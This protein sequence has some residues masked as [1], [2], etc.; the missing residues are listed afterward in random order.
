ME[1][2]TIIKLHI[3]L[4][5]IIILKCVMCS[6]STG[7]VPQKQGNFAQKLDEYFSTIK[8]MANIIEDLIPGQ[9]FCLNY[10]I[11]KV[12]QKNNI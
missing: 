9:Y 4:I 7:A 10:L 12:N 11:N 2:C 5:I 3:Y 8:C 1:M 6:I